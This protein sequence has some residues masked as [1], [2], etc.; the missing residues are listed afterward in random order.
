MNFEQMG[1]NN[2]PVVIPSKYDSRG[3]VYFIR[4]H[5]A[6]NCY[7]IGSSG[8]IFKRIRYLGAFGEVELLA[9]GYSH[10]RYLSEKQLQMIFYDKCNNSHI[11]KTMKTN[12]QIDFQWRG[13]INSTEYFILEHSDAIN[14]IN[15]MKTLCASV[16]I[17]CQ[18]T[19]FCHKEFQDSIY[20]DASLNF[21]YE[22]E[23]GLFLNY[24]TK[25]DRNGWPI[26]CDEE[27]KQC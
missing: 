7:K 13:D 5:Y 11:N 9:Y 10:D 25:F 8:N 16:Q 18:N 6:K 1:R 26:F 23:N 2:L 12:R 20:E 22:R 4:F 27:I 17:G 3:Y 15:C 19:E 24:P 21:Y 14:V